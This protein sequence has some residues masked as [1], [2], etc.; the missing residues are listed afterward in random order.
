MQFR[1]DNKTDFSTTIA[2]QE[3]KAQ[4]GAVV[5]IPDAL[6][7]FVRSR[8]CALTP[9]D[10]VAFAAIEEPGAAAKRVP[11]Y[12]TPVTFDED[13][14]PVEESAAEGESEPVPAPTPAVVSAVE[15]AMAELAAEQG[16]PARKPRKRRGA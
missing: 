7:H 11:L 4:P 2:G 13:N 6:C 8:G 12:S 1:N 14:A 9:L 5:E 15:A 3:F 16:L 10:E